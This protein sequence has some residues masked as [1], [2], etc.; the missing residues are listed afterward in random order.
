[1][2]ERLEA[3]LATQKDNPVSLIGLY[4]GR[5][6]RLVDPNYGLIIHEKNPIEVRK[7]MKR[8]REFAEEAKELSKQRSIESSQAKINSTQIVPQ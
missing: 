5:P 2:T 6:W 8:G 3:A 4:P 1:M 7:K